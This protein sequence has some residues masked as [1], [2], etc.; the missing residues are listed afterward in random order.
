MVKNIPDYRFLAGDICWATN[1]V[2]KDDYSPGKEI[3]E[4]IKRRPQIA[5][6]I[7]I[8]GA[9]I[10]SLHIAN[11]I[12]LSKIREIEPLNQE[13][14]G[15]VREINAYKKAND[16][17]RSNTMDV[18]KLVD[19]SIN[20]IE[21]AANLQDTIPLTV[22]ISNYEISSNKFIVEAVSLSQKDLDQFIV[23]LASHPMIDRDSISIIELN[24]SSNQP[25][26]D[27][28]SASQAN[29]QYSVSLTA[30][31]KMLSSEETIDL[32]MQS[33]NYGLLHKKNILNKGQA[34]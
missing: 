2:S 8:I 17:L 30:S 9:V 5:A 1:K 19:E 29:N 15:L 3:L 22:Q 6:P 32:I 24:A 21:F 26:G 12:L 18:R 33:G 25:G 10:A 4:K 28:N 13:Y 23:L 16:T 7:I 34:K 14:E 31:L 20:P 27:A 11:S